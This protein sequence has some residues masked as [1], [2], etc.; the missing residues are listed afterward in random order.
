MSEKS[1]KRGD[2]ANSLQAEAASRGLIK[3][4]REDD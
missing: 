4:R 3:V 1:M 2:R